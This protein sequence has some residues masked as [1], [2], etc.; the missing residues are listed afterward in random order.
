MAPCLVSDGAWAPGAP[1]DH[2]CLLLPI[3]GAYMPLAAH[4]WPDLMITA[5]ASVHTAVCP[6]EENAHSLGC[7]QH[8]PWVHLA[9][10]T[11]I[12]RAGRVLWVGPGLHLLLDRC[13]LCSGH[14]G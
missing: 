2:S 9:S 10:G 1:F 7:L 8:R 3:V 6:E 12:R 5:H 14:R 4:V 11:C 13:W